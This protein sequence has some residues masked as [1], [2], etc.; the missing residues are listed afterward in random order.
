MN[1]ELLR[2]YYHRFCR[3]QQA[4]PHYANR[5]E[6]EVQHCYNCDND[7]SGNFCPICGQRA[8]VERVGWKSIKDNVAILWGMDSRSLGYTLLQLLGRPGYLVRDYISGRRQVSF[9]PVKMLVIVCLFVVIVESVFHVKNDVIGLKFDIQEVD[10][11]IAWINSQKSW[12]T[13]FLQCFYILPTWLVFRYAPGYP[14]HTLP[15]GFFLQ[16]FLSVLS[17]LLTFIGYWN[18]NVELMLWIIYMYITYRQLFGYGWWGTLW[19]L[20][21]IFLLVL[22]TM[23]VA[24]VIIGIIFDSD[25]Y[26]AFFD[27]LIVLVAAVVLETIMLY[28]TR[29]I[30]K[31]N[32]RKNQDFACK[33]AEISQKTWIIRK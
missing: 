20:A 7:F 11:I 33:V 22:T 4:V 24:V 2:N 9:P 10:D 16:V 6:G 15:E 3:W 18:E 32:Y 12:A 13:L 5:H 19:R 21:V 27:I 26:D 17:L 31:R 1:K 23:V 8:E 14:R 28:I 25:Q 30:N 29:R